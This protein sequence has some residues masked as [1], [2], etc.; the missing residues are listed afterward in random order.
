[1]GKGPQRNYHTEHWS[2]VGCYAVS[3][4]KQV[5]VL[6]FKEYEGVQGAVQVRLHS[7]LTS[8]LDGSV[9]LWPF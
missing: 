2:F 4:G 8:A 5:Q 7:F 1:M 9:K 6:S 3:I